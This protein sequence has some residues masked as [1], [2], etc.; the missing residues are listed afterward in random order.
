LDQLRGS[1]KGNGNNDGKIFWGTM[2]SE[3]EN[4][5]N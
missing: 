1:L 3:S 2:E 4:D 5:E